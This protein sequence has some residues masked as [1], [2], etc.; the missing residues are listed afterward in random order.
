M[1]HFVTSQNNQE[2]YEYHGHTAVEWVRKQNGRVSRQWL[3]F[4][5][6]QEAADFYYEQ[7]AC[8]EAA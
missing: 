4:D 2:K 5:S 7:V 3:Y 1:T 6:A 8:C